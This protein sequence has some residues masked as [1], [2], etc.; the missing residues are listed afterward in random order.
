MAFYYS[1]LLKRELD[2]NYSRHPET[3]LA[4]FSFKHEII[5]LELSTS[6][7]YT[8][9]IAIILQIVVL[10]YLIQNLIL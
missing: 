1:I 4:V 10:L 9:I 8:A 3:Y 5:H 6:I 7:L 2:N